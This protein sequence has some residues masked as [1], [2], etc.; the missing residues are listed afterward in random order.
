MK[1]KKIWKV[2]GICGLCLILLI[3]GTYFMHMSP[4]PG[5]LINYTNYST[6]SGSYEGP[7]F[8]RGNF[9]ELDLKAN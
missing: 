5:A 4:R 6:A 1:N 8:E 3:S 7:L 9:V 2:I